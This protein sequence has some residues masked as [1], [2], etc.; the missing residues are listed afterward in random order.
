MKTNFDVA[1]RMELKKLTNGISIFKPTNA[2]TGKFDS[3]D[4]IFMS[5][6][7]E[8]YYTQDIF[9]NEFDTGEDYICANIMTKEEFNEKYGNFKTFQEALKQYKED[10]SK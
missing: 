1:I 9:M 7:G 2:I 4:S 3:T 8:S 6:D 5:F 10:S